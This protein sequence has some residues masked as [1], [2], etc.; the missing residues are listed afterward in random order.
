MS[1]AFDPALIQRYNIAGPRYTSYPT[2][3]QF[4]EIEPTDLDRAV[5]NSHLRAND[6]SLY[7]HLPFCATLCY[8][9]A[10]NKFVTRKYELATRYLK[11]LCKE[12]E[13]FAPS[14]KGRR[15]SQM[16]WGGGTPTFLNDQDIRTLME[17]IRS[18]YD[19]ADDTEGEFG[20]EIDPRTVDP[21]RVK[22]LRQVGFNRLSMGIQDFDP[23]VQQAVNRK[24]SYEAT[25]SVFEAAREVGFY[26]VSV[27]LIYG[28]PL[29]TVD[30]FQN[31]LSQVVDLG[32]DRISIFNY[33]HLPE[34]FPSQKRISLEDMPAAETKLAILERCI[35][36]LESAGYV[37][38]GLD[39]FA[40][41]ADSLA[42][43]LDEGKL[44][45]NFQ[46]YSTYAD[47]DMFAFG[48]TAISKVGHSFWQNTK[49]LDD[50]CDRLEQGQSPLQLGVE[51]DEDDQVRARVIKDLMCQF[52]VEFDHYDV[53]FNT[54]FAN[55]LDDLKRFEADGLIELTPTSLRVTERG[56][57]LVRNL[58][59]VFDRHLANIPKGRFS[60][61]V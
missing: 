8:Y 56:R 30:R 43:A 34:R 1:S 26:S 29:Q 53:V 3:L 39:H 31:T 4:H 20:I 45:R 14:V 37:R 52:K 48:V 23:L 15:I 44:H 17:F 58:C 16:H 61:A 9:C 54:Y 25:L 60:K 11:C 13:N 57:L 5:K 40:K 50:Y 47:S 21:E 7:L 46:G 51:V 24:Q 18:R 41:P 2:A 35:E 49:E 42:I 32:P 22:L 33:A 55:E 12:L 19:L 27:D 10:C 59:M 6:A 38:I 36:Y 28:L